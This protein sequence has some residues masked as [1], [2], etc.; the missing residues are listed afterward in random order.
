MEAQ[1]VLHASATF[2]LT[3]TPD[4][5]VLDESIVLDSFTATRATRL[6]AVTDFDLDGGPS[7]DSILASGTAP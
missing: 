7:D 3:D 2:T 1:G 6:Y 4:G 5:A